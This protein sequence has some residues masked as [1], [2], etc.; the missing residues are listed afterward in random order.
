[1]A[2]KASDCTSLAN[3]RLYHGV[4][5]RTARRASR[6]TCPTRV[7]L[8]ASR[9]TDGWSTILAVSSPLPLFTKNMPSC[10]AMSS[11]SGTT[12]TPPSE[13]LIGTGAPVPIKATRT[14]SMLAFSLAGIRRRAMTTLP[15]DTCHTFLAVR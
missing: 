6:S 4:M 9:A 12:N 14:S 15:L 3:G 1:M 5:A 7:T 8:H 13:T 11:L 2:Q 10:A